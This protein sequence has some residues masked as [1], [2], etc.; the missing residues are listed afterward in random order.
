MFK[1]VREKINITEEFR[2][3]TGTAELKD[4]EDMGKRI[5]DVGIQNNS[6]ISIVMRTRG[7]TITYE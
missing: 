1:A 2:L 4:P 5:Y 3:I 7:G 6:N